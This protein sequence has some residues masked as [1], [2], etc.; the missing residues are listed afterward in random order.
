MGFDKLQE[1]RHELLQ[2]TLCKQLVNS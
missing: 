2:Q 1:L